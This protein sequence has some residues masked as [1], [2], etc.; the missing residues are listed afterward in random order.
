ML[1]CAVQCV[2]GVLPPLEEQLC[3]LNATRP[4]P[5]ASHA[6]ASALRPAEMPACIRTHPCTTAPVRPTHATARPLLPQARSRLDGYRLPGGC[7][8]VEFKNENQFWGPGKRGWVCWLLLLPGPPARLF[9]C[10]FW[11]WHVCTRILSV[12]Q[13][14]IWRP[15]EHRPQPSACAGRGPPQGRDRGPQLYGG[16]D[17]PGSPPRGGRER[18][19]QHPPFREGGRAGPLRDRGSPERGGRSRSPDRSG[20]SREPPSRQASL[21]DRG[22]SRS[23]S[24]SR[25]RSRSRGRSREAARARSGEPGGS[26]G[27]QQPGVAQQAAQQ[28]AQQQRPASPGRPAAEAQAAGAGAG[29]RKRRWDAAADPQPQQPQQQE[30]QAPAQPQPQAPA[31][32]QPQAPPPQP[33]R[34][35]EQPAEQPAAVTV[36][37]PLPPP[38]RAL[39][40]AAPPQFAA[41]HSAP[42]AGGGELPRLYSVMSGGSL[43]QMPPGM[44]APAAAAAAPRPPG[45]ALPPPP[46]LPPPG[47]AGAPARPLMAKPPP[48]P[49]PPPPGTGQPAFP[50]PA[51]P[52]PHVPRPPVAPPPPGPPGRPSW[53]G[54][55]AKSRAPVCAAV[56][57]DPPVANSAAGGWAAAEPQQWPATL[58][59]AHRAD[60]Q[61]VCT[62]V[63][64]AGR[65]GVVGGRGASRGR[66][67]GP[68]VGGA[69][70]GVA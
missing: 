69:A 67:L 68:C 34:Q 39:P 66:E 8:R 31:Q 33:P 57:L 30:Q 21:R 5:V 18:Q 36:Q 64:R 22:R 70:P 53:Q 56:C 48:P 51:A 2:L 23:P 44:G 43:P 10:A 28:Q 54:T 45:L 65:L 52:P 35:P 50:P 47:M 61:F 16:R 41:P 1:C 19:S 7:L 6:A 27:R 13:C 62:Q 24:S 15:T 25:S 63:G 60:L 38:V 42:T 4:A 11:F 37:P 58:D 55:V 29:G 20:R 12:L 40:Q 32:P 26:P 9:G 46:S 59:V 49:Y 17:G 3:T 14:T